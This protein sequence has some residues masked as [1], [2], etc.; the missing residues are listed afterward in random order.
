MNDEPATSRVYR[1][2]RQALVE[3][4]Y[5]ITG[6]QWLAEDVVQEAWLRLDEARSR[7]EIRE[8]LRYLYRIVRNLSV[9]MLRRDDRERVYRG[10]DL[11][12]ATRLVADDTPSP[13]RV[14][15]DRE[16][17]R[18]VA[19]ALAELPERQRLAIEMYRL[20]DYKL[21]EIAERLG[22]SVSLVHHLIVEGMAYCDR[23]RREGR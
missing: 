19:A 6:S 9:D 3:Y 12:L 20:G 21:R 1:T 8:P 11:D 22:V 23:R 10:V 5:G 15:I 2:H 16:D 13:E 18:L 7:Q 4:A 14:A 17:M